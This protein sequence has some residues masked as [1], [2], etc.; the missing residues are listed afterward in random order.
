[1]DNSKSENYQASRGSDIRHQNPDSGRI[2][3]E[4][5][6]EPALVEQ[7]RVLAQ[8][9][10]DERGAAVGQGR[11]GPPVEGEGEGADAGARGKGHAG[12]VLEV[13]RAKELLERSRGGAHGDGGKRERGGAAEGEEAGEAG[14]VVRWG[15][16]GHEAAGKG[17]AGVGARGHLR[18]RGGC[19]AQR[20]DWQA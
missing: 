14:R 1:M 11:R 18:R 7:L 13:M 2:P 15:G 12:E 17:A 3:A 16:E 19:G 10:Y 8:R 5:T 20:H 9:G 6:Q 4:L